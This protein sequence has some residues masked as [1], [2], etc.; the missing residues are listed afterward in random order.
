MRNDFK[1]QDLRIHFIADARG[2]GLFNKAD[3]H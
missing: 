3:R 2:N 1:R